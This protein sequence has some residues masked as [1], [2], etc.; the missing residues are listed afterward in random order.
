M[1]L[2]T[3]LFRP[4]RVPKPRTTGF[5]KP[6]PLAGAE[7]A[8]SDFVMPADHEDNPPEPNTS[9]GPLQELPPQFN[10]PSRRSQSRS[11]PLREP[12]PMDVAF[13]FGAD[14]N[15][16]PAD[17]TGPESTATSKPAPQSQPEPDTSA[18]LHNAISVL[19]AQKQASRPPS[20]KNETTSADAQPRRRKKGLLGRASSATSN[21]SSFGAAGAP[22]SNPLSRT[23]SIA[24]EPGPAT[25]ALQQQVPVPSQA[26]IFEDPS[27]QR[28]RE[29]MIRRMGGKVVKSRVVSVEGVGVVRDAMIEEAGGVASRVRRRARGNAAGTEEF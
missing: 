22:A 24:S 25:Q 13:S 6:P 16:S 12:P 1:Q 3:L 23:S 15:T 28:Q 29:D 7:A 19:L 20:A 8:Q 2:L 26:L 21:P 9:G 18:N 5:R 17:A 27:V 4:A 11:Q 10:S 14:E